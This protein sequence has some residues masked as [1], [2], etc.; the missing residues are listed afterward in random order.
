MAVTGFK[1][2]EDT[3]GVTGAISDDDEE[4]S[5]DRSFINYTIISSASDKITAVLSPKLNLA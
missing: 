5:R 4:Q 2:A 1:N 3:D